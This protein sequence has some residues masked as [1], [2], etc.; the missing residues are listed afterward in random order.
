MS[1]IKR[2]LEELQEL[3]EGI[4]NRLWEDKK[5]GNKRSKD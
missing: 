4:L 3:D 5:D 1:Q 2:M